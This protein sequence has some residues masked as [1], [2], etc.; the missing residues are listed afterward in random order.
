MGPRIVNASSSAF[1]AIEDMFFDSEA[2]SDESTRSWLKG[3]RKMYTR[4][5]MRSWTSLIIAILVPFGLPSFC[6]MCLSSMCSMPEDALAESEQE[7]DN[8]KTDQVD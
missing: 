3:K 4:F 2:R 7:D 5:A 1:H 6:W 8:K